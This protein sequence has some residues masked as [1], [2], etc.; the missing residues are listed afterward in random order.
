MGGWKIPH[1]NSD[2]LEY[3]YFGDAGMRGSRDSS[4]DNVRDNGFHYFDTG[5]SA[6]FFAEVNRTSRNLDYL[7]VVLGNEKLS[8]RS[9][10]SRTLSRARLHAPLSERCR[11]AVRLLSLI[12]AVGGNEPVLPLVLLAVLS[13]DVKGER[14]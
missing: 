6:V 1:Y 12:A 9:C 4:S 10:N 5:V 14:S 3:I 13:V 8:D 11:C 7:R 2:V